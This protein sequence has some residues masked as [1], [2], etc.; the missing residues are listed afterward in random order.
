MKTISDPELLDIWERA[1]A[2][3]PALRP[4]VLL[5]LLADEA[6]ADRLPIGARDRRLLDLRQRWL[7]SSFEGVAEC[8]ACGTLVEL[9][10]EAPPAPAEPPRAASDAYRLPDSRDLRAVAGCASVAEAR[11]RLAERCVQDDAPLTDDAIA[12][13]AAEMERDDPDG[14]F[15]SDVTCPDCAHVWEVVF[16]PAAWV[17]SELESAA[18][19]AIREVDALAAAYGWSEREI[20]SLSP[21]RRRTYLEMVL[22]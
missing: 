12:A 9:T 15:R 18:L 5:Q 4:A 7:G 2:A 14:D 21:A 8:P 1:R 20:L 13:L 22:G 16:D 10:F 17:W 3:H 6:D 11:R 19:G